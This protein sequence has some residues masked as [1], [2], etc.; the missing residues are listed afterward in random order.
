MC[1]RLGIYNITSRRVEQT[2]RQ[3]DRQ[4]ETLKQYRDLHA[5]HA[6]A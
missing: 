2:D 6:G 5:M 4:T 1:I 3:T